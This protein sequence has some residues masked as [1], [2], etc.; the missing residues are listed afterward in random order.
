M[1]KYKY[2][3]NVSTNL[4]DYNKYN[5]SSLHLDTTVFLTFTSPCEGK[6]RLRDTSL[7]H[8]RSKYDED[9]SDLAGSEFKLNVEKYD[10]RFAF[11]DGQ[12]REVC[13]HPKE[14]TWAL[15][16]KR[17]V[18]SM[19]QNTMKR[20]DL[21]RRTN[22]LDINGICETNYRLYEA[23]KTSLIVKKRKNLAS[24]S[25]SGKQMT[26]IQSTT[27]RSSLS[28]EKALRR[29]LLGSYS[30]CDIMIDH[31]IYQ[32]VECTDSHRLHPL[33]T[34]NTA[35]ARSDFKSKLELLSEDT[36]SDVF[37]E[38]SSE[39]S[40]ENEED[41]D[42]KEL[43]DETQNEQFSMKRSNLLYDHRRTVKTISR[44]LNSSK[45]LL[46]S[47]CG[48]AGKAGEIKQR[49]AEK[50]TELVHALRWLDYQSLHELDQSAEEICPAGK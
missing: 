27:Y 11:D 45:E 50:F 42:T 5:E 46:K 2:E 7:S 16:L 30:D 39:E 8:D 18:L 48:L 20:F 38:Q 24:C 35:G 41:S 4:G 49:F 32:K 17:G 9:S 25:H 34:G 47:I 31:N 37:D 36:D 14:D 33:S 3:V 23:Q 40:E 13:S 26:M 44:E 6:I 21:D 19:F 29:P 10:M 28:H 15:N 43:N 1:Y 22:E 12:V